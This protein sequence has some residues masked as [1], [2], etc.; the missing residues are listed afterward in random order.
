MSLARATHPNTGKQ[1][2]NKRLT[3]PFMQERNVMLS[4]ERY[5]F[6]YS[7]ARELGGRSKAFALAGR[8]NVFL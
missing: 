7:Q 4:C 5:R 3:S 2:L 8:S 6:K 1:P